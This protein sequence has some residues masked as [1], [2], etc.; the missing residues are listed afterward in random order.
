MT[1]IFVG[2][3]PIFN[4]QL[5][6]IGYELL[7]RSMRSTSAPV[8]DGD[9]AT[10]NVMFN[11]FVEIGLE[12]ITGAQRA[13]INLT[14]NFITGKYPIPL[15]PGRVIL[16]V[17]ENI[18]VDNELIV[19]L[20]SLSAQGYQIALDDITDLEKLDPRLVDACHIIKVD[21]PRFD[22]SRDDQVRTFLKQHQN[23]RLLAEKVET[24]EDLAYCK[25]LGFH[26]YQGFFL[27][28]PNI[29]EGRQM[30]PEK[31]VVLNMLSRLQ[32]PNITFGALE[33][34]VVCDPM[35][36]Y[37]LLRL[38]NSV[39]YSVPTIIESIRQAL[40]LI[41]LRQLREWLTL[42]LLTGVPDKPDEL[43]V[44]GMMRARM[45][46][47]IALK[48]GI[49]RPDSYRLAGLFSILDALLDTTLD[50]VVSGI[51]L[52]DELVA[53]LLNHE[54]PIGEVLKLTLAYERGDWNL[55]EQADLPPEILQKIYLETIHWT[56]EVKKVLLP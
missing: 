51:H 35:L 55:V 37:K 10:S 16:E 38:I 46:E 17:V 43:A 3:Q 30:A 33:E 36:G 45:C 26:Y 22:R 18:V 52:A 32:D 5:N 24:Q 34:I 20:R 44:I 48:K 49:T 31:M 19:G 11:A 56:D 27:C 14:R 42:M 8:G 28:R 1:D 47:Q 29:V 4:Q 54:G 15:P 9:V 40:T 2:R 12:N 41:G 53:A 39:F 25:Q 21:L 7:Y 50:Q 6:V 23:A 13:F